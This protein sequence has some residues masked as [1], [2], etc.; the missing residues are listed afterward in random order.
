MTVEPKPRPSQAAEDLW[1][2]GFY[3]A[4]SVLLAVCRAHGI[5]SPLLPGVASPFCSGQARTCG[6]CGALSGALMALGAVLGRRSEKESMDRIYAATQS[7]IEEFEREF[8]S[9][10]CQTLLDGCDLGTPAGQIMF[11]DRNF[12]ERCQRFTSRAAAM[13]DRIIAEQH[14]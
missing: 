2:A 4:E 12:R 10:N 8:G 3:C 13:A 1:T 5:E 6:P 14:G 7:L 9:R 11:R